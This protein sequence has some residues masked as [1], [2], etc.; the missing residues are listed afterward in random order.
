[1]TEL[2][3]S[4]GEITDVSPLAGLMLLKKLCLVGNKRNVSV[5]CKHF[6]GGMATRQPGDVSLEP[7]DG[8]I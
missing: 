6:T 1:M 4:Y 2:N 8:E 5:Y 7:T 3:L